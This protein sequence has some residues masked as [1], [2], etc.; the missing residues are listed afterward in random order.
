MR[1]IDDEIQGN[2]SI[3]QYQWEGEE[4]EVKL[5]PRRNAKSNISFTATKPS[6]K[7]KLE[8]RLV[9]L[10]PMIKYVFF[11]IVK[12][13]YIKGYRN[14]EPLI[15]C[16]DLRADKTIQKT[17]IAKSDSRITAIVLKELVAAEG[18]GITDHVINITRAPL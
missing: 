11:V 6:V 12:S 13:K 18:L 8:R 10:Q 3:L 16:T 1:N 9:K 2:V 4:G 15:L 7:E 14:G 17:A 5:A